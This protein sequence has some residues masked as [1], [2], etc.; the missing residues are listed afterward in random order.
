MA[1][2]ALRTAQSDGFVMANIAL[3]GS[4]AELGIDC[5]NLWLQPA[6]AAHGHSLS[7]G[8]DAYLRAPLDVPL[9]QLPL[10]L[11]FPSAKDRAWAAAHPRHSMCQVLALAPHAWFAKYQGAERPAARHAP[12]ALG[13]ES[14][15]EY[16]ELKR[17]WAER[18]E[19]ALL[20]HYPST[21]GRVAFVNISTP[22]TI[23]HY[24]P[25]TAG[26]AIGLD[27]TP[28]RFTDE[29]DMRRLDMRTSVRGLWLTGQ[30]T[31]MAGQPLAQL[32]GVITAL[33]IAGPVRASGVVC[34]TLLL[35][36]GLLGGATTSGADAGERKAQ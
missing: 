30:D 6:G 33:R 28:S 27:V 29:G 3:D 14:Q 5:T 8:V 2:S 26:S 7:A 19:R 9:G 23:E 32:A 16:D 22:L 34:R 25:S 36:L 10:M 20:E 11:T 1:A 35:K 31:L 15:A 13:R 12:P 4:A 18:C 24:L 21:K 17:R